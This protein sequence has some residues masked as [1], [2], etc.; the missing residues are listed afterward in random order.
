[1]DHETSLRHLMRL[2]AGLESLVL[3]EDQI[4]GQLRDAV[5][6]ARSEDGIGPMLED[7]LMKAIHVGERARTE[8][9]INEGVVSL[10]SAAV[11][12]AD[13]EANL[14]GATALVVGAGEMGTIAAES[15]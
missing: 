13:H 12:L 8:T 15:L 1:M 9:A 5:E 6:T 11:T 10:G 7:T 4:I 14:D 3:G 2:A